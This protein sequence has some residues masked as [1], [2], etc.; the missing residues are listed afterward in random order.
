MK[1]T[2]VGHLCLD[3]VHRHDG[4]EKRSYGGIYFAVAAM[5]NIASD[6]DT[7]FPVFGVGENE[8]D[9][10]RERL[11]K[12]PNVNTDGLFSFK[13]ETN[14]VHLF[15]TDKESRTECSKHISSPIPFSR[16]E[17][18][19]AVQG[20]FL[21]MISGSDITLETL[22][23]IGSRCARRTRRFTLTYTV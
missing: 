20:I 2:V 5:A 9:E 11:A 3:V 7:V 1:L 12:Y 22:D 4:T 15:Y 23:Q 16:V 10:V 14:Q 13:G 21:D 18:F 17:P 6:A 8:F 19:L